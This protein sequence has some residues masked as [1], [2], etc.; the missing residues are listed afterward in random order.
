MLIAVQQKLRVALTQYWRL[1]QCS[2]KK[3]CE[4]DNKLVVVSDTLRR[5]GQ[6]FLNQFAADVIWSPALDNFRVQIEDP[7][8][9]DASARVIVSLVHAILPRIRWRKYFRCQH[10]AANRTP[11]CRHTTITGWHNKHIWLR[12]GTGFQ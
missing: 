7:V 11:F 8:F 9:C 6:L 3:R 4:V 2:G 5:P 10:Q 12:N 1:L